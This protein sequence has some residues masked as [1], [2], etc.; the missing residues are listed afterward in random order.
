MEEQIY[1]SIPKASVRLGICEKTLRDWCKQDK[2]PH[3][4][5]GNKFMVDIPMTIQKLREG[6]VK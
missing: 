2:I 5:C 3:I 4:M 1:L 6:G